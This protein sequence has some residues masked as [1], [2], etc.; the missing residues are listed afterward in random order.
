M[1]AK[2]PGAPVMLLPSETIKR[3]IERHTGTVGGGRLTLRE[4]L[5]SLPDEHLVSDS[6]ASRI[7]PEGRLRRRFRRLSRHRSGRR[8]ARSARCRSL[9]QSGEVRVVARKQVSGSTTRSSS[10]AS[11]RRWMHTPTSSRRSCCSSHAGANL[12]VVRSVVHRRGWGSGRLFVRYATSARLAAE[13]RP[14]ADAFAPVRVESGNDRPVS[15]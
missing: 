8:A 3:L 11:A 13:P 14:T 10:S 5:L 7:A 9:V 6:K 2:H 4:H 15:R 1:G 12:V